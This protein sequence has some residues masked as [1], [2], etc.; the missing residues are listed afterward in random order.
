MLLSSLP[1]DSPPDLSFVGASSFPGLRCNFK[2]ISSEVRW[3]R[4]GVRERRRRLSGIKGSRRN[5]KYDQRAGIG[6][7]LDSV[8]SCIISVM[9]WIIVRR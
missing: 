8:F 7:R 2:L 4:C 1:S 3:A 5:S 6:L 9:I